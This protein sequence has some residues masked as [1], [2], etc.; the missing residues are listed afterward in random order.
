MIKKIY[1][2][3]LDG[4]CIRTIYSDKQVKVGT[5]ISSEF[6]LGK[7]MNGGIVTKVFK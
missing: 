7:K 2:I 4:K 5:Y 1:L 6:W 3:E